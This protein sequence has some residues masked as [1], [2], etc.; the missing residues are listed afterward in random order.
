MS[1]IQTM[2][3]AAC[4]GK[5]DDDARAQN[6]RFTPLRSHVISR[7]F[8]GEGRNDMALSRII[9]KPRPQN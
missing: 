2:T 8:P 6:L 5:T 4:S 1:D 7:T 3:E 9:P